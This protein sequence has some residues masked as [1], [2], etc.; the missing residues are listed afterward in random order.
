MFEQAFRNIDYIL[1]G[2]MGGTTDAGYPEPRPGLSFKD[3]FYG[4]PPDK[5]SEARPLL[6]QLEQVADQSG[7]ARARYLFAAF[8]SELFT[9]GRVSIDQPCH[10]FLVTEVALG[11]FLV[12]L[13]K[14]S[15]DEWGRNARHKLS[16]QRET[17]S[18]E[19][20]TQAGGK[21]SGRHNQYVLPNGMY[22]AQLPYLMNWLQEFAVTTGNGT[23]QLARVVRLE[24]RGQ[25]YRHRDRGLYY[26]I[27]D[28]YHLVLR[29][30]S[31]SR[32][33]CEDR[34]SVW[35][36]GELWWF[37]NHVPHQA[38]NDS[39]DERIH[40]IFD[41]LPYRNQVFVPY[42]QLY[43]QKFSEVAGRSGR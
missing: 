34:F 30:L 19:L 35:R 24:A 14:I 6:E 12:E 41:V 8:V 33:Q 4:L 15:E 10:F 22:S 25:V 28:R 26:L 7:L 27:R 42:F 43:A 29:S 40:V 17:R 3:Y 36:S 16:V 37:N 31:G 2:E 18:I 21:V 32:M 5:A 13:A 11:P 23:L 9:S 1:H 39:V 38:F 20:S